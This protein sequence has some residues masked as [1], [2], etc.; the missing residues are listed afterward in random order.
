MPPPTTAIRKGCDGSLL[1]PPFLAVV[2]VP[3]IGLYCRSQAS[4]RGGIYKICGDGEFVDKDVFCV[5]NRIFS[6]Q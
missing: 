4:D 5:V 3:S 1:G 2:S 6:E